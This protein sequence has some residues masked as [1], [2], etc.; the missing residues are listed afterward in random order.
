MIRVSEKTEQAHIVQ[1]LRALGAKVYVLGHG[2]P[3]DG[4]RHRGTGQT[5]GLP[6]LF[7]FLPPRGDAPRLA[8]WI[9][10]KA[11]GG[12][13]RDE[14]RAFAKL[15]TDAMVDHIVGTLDDVIGWLIRHG[16]CG[17]HQFPSY[18]VAG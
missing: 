17:A 9:E 13:V 5:P 14:Q 3:N 10:C 2:S 8:L 16:Y 6:D 4:R 15:C 7:C 1:L 11:K 18:R 12:K